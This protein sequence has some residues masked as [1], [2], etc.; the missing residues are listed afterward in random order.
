M[1]ASFT[2]GHIVLMKNEIPRR[3]PGRGLIAALQLDEVHNRIN[4]QEGDS[5]NAEAVDQ[6]FRYAILNEGEKIVSFLE[7]IISTGDEHVSTSRPGI[8]ISSHSVDQLAA[9]L[10]QEPEAHIR[11]WPSLTPTYLSDGFAFDLIVYDKLQKRLRFIHMAYG[12]STER[13]ALVQ[14]EEDKAKL[15]CFLRRMGT[16]YFGIEIERTEFVIIDPLLGETKYLEGV[17]A[18]RDLDQLTG[19]PGT[20]Q[21]VL[22]IRR[23]Q[24]HML[25]VWFGKSLPHDQTEQHRQIDSIINRFAR[26]ELERAKP[27]YFETL[28]PDRAR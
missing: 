20:A 4:K 11:Q 13:N 8:P 19:R 21:H 25:S 3:H 5:Q 23:Q 7:S 27:L 28:V 18:L 1:P 9:V 17:W 10:S 14:Y 12:I 2:I 26:E 16:Q 6:Y 22:E 24:R 15:A